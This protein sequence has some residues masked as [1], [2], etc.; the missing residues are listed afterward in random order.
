MPFTNVTTANTNKRLHSKMNSQPKTPLTIEN[1]DHHP[2]DPD[3]QFLCQSTA[4]KILHPT[5]EDEFLGSKKIWVPGYLS[6][7]RFKV[8]NPP[9][10]Q[11]SMRT[12]ILRNHT[13]SLV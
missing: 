11:R 13:E 1:E 2:Y 6:K 7:D 8:A 3:F 9:G 5:L 12:Q 10:T 4:R